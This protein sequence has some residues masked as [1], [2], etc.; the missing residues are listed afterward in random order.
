MCYDGYTV[1]GNETNVFWASDLFHRMLHVPGVSE[2]VVDHWTHDLQETLVLAKN[3]TDVRR[4]SNS[5]SLIY[6][7]LEVYAEDVAVPGVGCAGEVEEKEEEHEHTE[8]TATTT[9]APKASATD[10]EAGKD[11]HTHADGSLHCV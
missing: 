10:A 7:A 5:D 4:G 8:T 2:G 3:V 9:T 11:C 6:F 1:A